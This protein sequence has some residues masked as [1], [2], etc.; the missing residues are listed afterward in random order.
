MLLTDL[1]GLPVTADGRRVGY[2]NDV[3]LVLDG[4]P[5]GH[6]AK[7]RLH[8]LVV[9]PGRRGSFLGYERVDVDRPRL[10]NSFL[11]RRHA[12]S[13][14]VL[15]P[16]VSAVDPDGVRLLTGYQAYDPRL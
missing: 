15:W 11:A 14:L 12:G 2:V 3:R 13:V 5:D 16:D 6:L 10:I 1:I 7:P 9:S 8:G 4:P